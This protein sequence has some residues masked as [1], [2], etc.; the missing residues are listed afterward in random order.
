M[1]CGHSSAKTGRLHSAI[2][3]RT[4]LGVFWYPEVL[5]ALR[6]A[7]MRGAL[8]RDGTTPSEFGAIL[9]REIEKYARL[10]KLSGPRP[11]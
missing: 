9:G 10:I 7:E 11:E 4:Q 2:S 5:T 8:E 1:C 6:S 3:L